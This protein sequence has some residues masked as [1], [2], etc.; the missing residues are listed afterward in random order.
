MGDDRIELEGGEFMGNK[1]W[2]SETLARK[3]FGKATII[4]PAEGLR[5][6]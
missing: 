2:P 6:L 5:G 3:K 4:Y 1:L